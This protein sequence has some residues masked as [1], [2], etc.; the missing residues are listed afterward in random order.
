MFRGSGCVGG[1][2]GL[3]GEFGV[4]D[5]VGNGAVDQL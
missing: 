3:A 2:I 4:G 5:G 1:G